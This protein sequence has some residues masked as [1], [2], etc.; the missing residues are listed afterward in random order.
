MHWLA[1]V[2]Q[3]VV[4]LAIFASPVLFLRMA[5]TLHARAQRRQVAAARRDIARVNARFAA[6]PALIARAA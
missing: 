6:M 4:F 3:F 5:A 1:T 2:T